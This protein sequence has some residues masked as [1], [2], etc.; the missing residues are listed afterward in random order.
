MKHVDP[1]TKKTAKKGNMRQLKREFAKNSVEEQHGELKAIGLREVHGA[2]P[3]TH[4]NVSEK[5]R[6]A[7][8]TIA[9]LGQKSLIYC[10]LCCE[11]SPVDSQD[12]AVHLL[13]QEPVGLRFRGGCVDGKVNIGCAL[14]SKSLQN[15]FG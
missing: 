13:L 12:R 2:F 8:G 6:L 11:C 1:A 3:A 5:R 15:H 10:G 14:G 7:Y 4:I 9:K